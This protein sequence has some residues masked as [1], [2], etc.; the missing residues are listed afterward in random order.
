MTTLKAQ[1]VL[2]SLL[3]VGIAEVAQ[4]NE[5]PRPL[6]LRTVPLPAMEAIS[7]DKPSF[8]VVD[9][10]GNAVDIQKGIKAGL[11]KGM[12]VTAGDDFRVRS[13]EVTLARGTSIVAKI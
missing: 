9:R 5:G 11:I 2:F 10:S 8:T 4:S 12:K 7:T 13:M 6:Q 3:L 1:K